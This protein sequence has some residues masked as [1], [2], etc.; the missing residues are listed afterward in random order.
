MD[1]SFFLF[2]CVVAVW[3]YYPSQ[4]L[5]ELFGE[6]KFLERQRIYWEFTRLINCLF[7]SASLVSLYQYIFGEW[8][9]FGGWNLVTVSDFTKEAVAQPLGVV[10]L[11]IVLVIPLGNLILSIVVISLSYKKIKNP[12][13]NIFIKD[14]Y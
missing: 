12:K 2:L 7:L 9:I 10:A 4:W 6:I 13:E 8:S 14:S 3:L 1:F 5:L 11:I